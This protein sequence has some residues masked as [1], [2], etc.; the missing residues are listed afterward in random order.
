MAKDK[1]VFGS[2]LGGFVARSNKLR[3]APTRV[4]G[5]SGFSAFVYQCWLNVD[6][7]GASQCYGLDRDDT[8]TQKFPWQKNLTPWERL[9]FHSGSLNNARLGGSRANRW[10]SIVVR[11][12][13][14]ALDLLAKFFP[15]WSGLDATAR[16]KALA[17]FWDNR[18]D[19]QSFGS[20][21]DL[22]GNGKFPIVQLREMGQPAPGYYVS[23]SQAYVG[24]Y[25]YAREWDQNQYWDAGI[26]P[27]SVVPKLPGVRVGDFGLAVR[28]S[29][30]DSTAFFFGD[31]GGSGGSSKLGECSGFLYMDLGEKEDEYYS[32]I[33]FPGSGSGTADGD[34]LGRMDNVVTAQIS[35]LVNTG[36]ALAQYLAPRDPELLK[37]RMAL[38]EWG[39]PRP[40]YEKELSR[41]P[42]EHGGPE[43]RAEDFPGS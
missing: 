3:I 7:D 24:T 4:T 8:P 12:K 33:V 22:R 5:P 38:F 42:R 15:G 29:T 19:T 1:L 40:D 41:F 25:S 30:G 6:W 35:K 43:T 23:P 37:T 21:E 28:N 14:E 39:G 17:Q 32:F 9:D 36:N 16:E 27:Y 20:L 2:P 10:S 34:A 26:V 13:G 18:T 11:T 31:T